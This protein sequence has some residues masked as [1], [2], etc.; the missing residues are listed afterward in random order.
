M[1]RVIHII[2]VALLRAKEQ[3]FPSQCVEEASKSLENM[4]DKMMN[5]N[6]DQNSQPEGSACMVGVESLFLIQGLLDQND[7]AMA[8]TCS[9]SDLHVLGTPQSTQG[10]PGIRSLL[11]QFR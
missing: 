10:H 7:S 6:G 8:G 11:T 3:P 5:R 1:L 9:R 4:L 2:R